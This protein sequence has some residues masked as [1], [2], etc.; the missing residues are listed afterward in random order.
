MKRWFLT[1]PLLV[2]LFAPAYSQITITAADMPVAG[3]SLRYSNASATTATT[4]IADSG[5][6]RTWNYMLTP[7]SQ[8]MDTYKKPIQVNPLFALTI[9]N[10]NSYGYKIADS[11]PGLSMLVPGI[12]ISNLYTFYSKDAAQGRFVAESFGATIS[13]FPAGA[14]Y[15]IPD[16]VYMFPLTYNRNDSTEFLLE[17]GAPTFGS[18][19]QHGYRKTRVDG[20]GTITTPYFTKPTPCIRVRSEITEIDSVVL[21]SISFGLP[22]TTIEYKWLVNGEHYPALAITTLSLAGFEVPSSLKYRDIYRPDLNKNVVN[23]TLDANDVFAYPNPATDGWVRFE[24]PNTWGDYYIELFDVQ[25]RSVMAMA[26]NW[27]FDVSLLPTG[28]YI[29]RIT[30]GRS[31]AYIKLAR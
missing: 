12:S 24:I 26:N 11:I 20:W 25:G 17:F 4:Y 14:N 21:D 29:V 15:T 19:R 23:I 10:V 7:T 30:S 8:G 22:R 13:N 5:E 9:K 16:A 18:I 3:D 1:A 28:N 27:Q 6:N 31:V 2:F